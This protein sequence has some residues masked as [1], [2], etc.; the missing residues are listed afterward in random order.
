MILKARYRGKQCRWR[1]R[2][3]VSP[4]WLVWCSQAEDD[5]EE[6]TWLCSLFTLYAPAFLRGF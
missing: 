4:L 2:P 3:A 1:L 6:M 5:G